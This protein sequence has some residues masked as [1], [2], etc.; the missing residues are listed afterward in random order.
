M[1]LVD[2][3]FVQHDGWKLSADGNIIFV[4][5]VSCAFS[6]SSPAADV[7]DSSRCFEFE[8]EPFNCP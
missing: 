7:C 1:H 2:L 4:D 3:I 6:S 5:D 8:F